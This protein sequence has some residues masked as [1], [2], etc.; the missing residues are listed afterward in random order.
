MI[1]G[2]KL[3]APDGFGELVKDTTYHFLVSDSSVNRVRLVFFDNVGTRADLI[4]LTRLEFEAALE[5]GDLIEVSGVEFYPDWLELTN[6]VDISQLERMRVKPKEGYDAKVN[7]RFLAISELV[8]RATEILAS[9]DPES[10][11]NAH[12]KNQTPQQNAKRLRFWFFSYMVFGQ[13]KWALMPRLHKIGSWDRTGKTQEKLGRPSRAGRKAGFPVTPEMKEKILTGFVRLKGVEKTEQTIYGSVLTKF[14]RCR[15]RINLQGAKEFYHPK[16]DPF[17]SFHQFKYWVRKQTDPTS[18]A[19]DLKGP[20]KARAESGSAGSFAAKL[21]NLNQ[22]VEFDGFYPSAKLSGLTEG[23]ALDAFCVVRAVCA[24]SG[25]VV[26]VGFSDGRENME[27]YRM[28]L[29]SMAID[30]VKFGELFG[31]EVKIGEWTSVGVANNIVFDR[32]P[33]AGMDCQEA[34]DWLTRLELTPTHSGQSKATVESSHP[35]DKKN[36]DQATHFHSALN[37]VEMSR[38]QIYRTINDNHTSNAASRMTEEMWLAGFTPTPANIWRYLDD[39]GRNSG[40][41]MP[42]DQAVRLFL[43]PHPATIRRDAVYF[44]GR[45]YNAKTLIDT[46]IYDRVARKGQV[47]VTAYAITMCV[48]H[49]WVEVDGVIHE[50][51]FVHSAGVKPNSS[52]ISLYDLKEINEARLQ[53][54]ALLRAEQVPIEQELMSRFEVDTGKAW[55]SGRRKLGRAAKD[56]SAQRDIADYRRLMG[57]KH[58]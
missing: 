4:T 50:L 37:F 25:A 53:S 47:P 52:D 18:L 16:G 12:A 44:Y 17:P 32:G 30:K 21:S 15:V 9:E 2:S 26:G 51:S 36:N 41:G 22:L 56:A 48:R 38:L 20:S 19:R 6:G 57:K 8:V 42:F 27:A 1:T 39:R 24:L 46:R 28:A 40:I 7:R 23:S 35:R 29:F 34:I 49:I 54:S 11:I 43:T 10:I 45:K 55:D 31:A 13:N 3:R 5:A 33:A 58:D 14:F